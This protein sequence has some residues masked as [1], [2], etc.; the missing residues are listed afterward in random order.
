MNIC[1]PQLGLSPKS[2]LGGEVF[3][4]EILTG[5]AQK[6]HQIDVILPKGLPHVARN[7]IRIT[8]LPV[9]HFP[10][11][12]FNLLALPYIFKVNKKNKV[13][14]LR[15]HQPQF[16]FL[17]ALI[18]KIFNRDVKTVAVYHQFHES[19]FSIFSRLINHNWD[20]IVCDSIAVKNRLIKSYNVKSRK[21]LV[22]H[23]GVPKYL[24]PAKKDKL[25]VK[26]LKLENKLVLLFMGLFIPRKN[27]LFLLELLKKLTKENKNIVIL[28]LGKGPLESKIIEKAKEMKLSQN[29]RI[30]KPIFGKDKIKIHNLADIFVHPSLDE[31]FALTPLEAMACGKPVI[32]NDSHSASEAVVNGY[33]GILCKENNIR[34]WEN[35]VKLISKSTKSMYD[36][37]SNSLKKAKREFNWE[38]SVGLHNQAFKNMIVENESD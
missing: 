22:V 28:F 24:K 4:V 20:L 15:L 2:I 14:I 38:K 11:F 31:G 23:N 29:F 25:L 35:A 32:M 5:L 34:S 12:L 7:N 36:Y 9:A 37:G 8:Y 18:F 13:Q 21:I 27:P 30:I 1:S 33:N 6:G 16:L 19:S 3:D 17:S 10:A 26:K